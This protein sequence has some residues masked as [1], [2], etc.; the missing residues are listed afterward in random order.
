MGVCRAFTER[1]GWA[2]AQEYSDHAV[3]G[4][5]LLR[6]GFQALMRDALNRQFGVVLPNRS[7]G[8]AAT[9]K[10]PLASSND[11]HSPA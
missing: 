1:Q 10:T 8:S 5:T 7:I 11:S 4:A 6:S 9:R 2:I 3:S